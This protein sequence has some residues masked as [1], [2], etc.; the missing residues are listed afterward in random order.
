[1]RATAVT[2]RRPLSRRESEAIGIAAQ[3]ALNDEL[4]TWPKPGL[5]SH[6]D[7]GSHADMDAG[8]FFR[9][10]AVL[11]PFFVQ[12]ACAGA[13]GGDMNCLRHL[14]LQAEKAMLTATKGVNT[15]RGAIFGL[16]L[17][18]ASAGASRTNH[19]FTAR[20]ASLGDLVVQKWG[21]DILR[22]LATLNSH[23]TEARLRFGVGGATGQ[24]AAGFPHAYSVGLP[25]LKLGRV[26]APND[27]EA[28]RVQT[29]FALLASLDDTNL[30]HRGGAEG[31]AF[32]HEQ[33]T[34]FLEAGGVG[35]KDWKIQAARIHWSFVQRGLSPGGC[36]DLLAITIFLDSQEGV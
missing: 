7:N 14:G 22:G 16:G 25:A 12:L 4:E 9:S 1:M 10:A 31:L 21:S 34:A 8:L 32:A 19:F 11:Q 17:L 26:L 30:L 35:Q 18:C 3:R 27:E 2:G 23:G 28:S 15:H 36:A 29:F 5:V 20:P 6:V 33:A 24:A 13:A